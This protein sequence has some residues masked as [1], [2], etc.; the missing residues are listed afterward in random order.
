MPSPSI[1]EVL[2]RTFQIIVVYIVEPG[3]GQYLLNLCVQYVEVTEPPSKVSSEK[4][5]IICL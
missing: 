5:N 4:V 3:K 1:Y 2:L